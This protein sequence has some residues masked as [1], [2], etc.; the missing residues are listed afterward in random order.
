VDSEQ[1]GKGK[2]F[3]RPVLI[4]RGFSKTT[5]MVV[6]LS[7]AETVNQYRITAGI[8]EGRKATALISQVRTIDTKRLRRK[9]GLL[10]VETYETI[11]KAV[12]ELF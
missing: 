10:D 1:D 8:V 6:P 7:T 11:K 9:V 2:S 5:C 12:R 4:I 3:T